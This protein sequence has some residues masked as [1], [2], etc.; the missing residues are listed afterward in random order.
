MS[1]GLVDE[2]PG[3]DAITSQQTLAELSE[4][5]CGRLHDP[6]RVRHRLGG[7]MN[8]LVQAQLAHPRS[9]AD[10]A[11]VGPNTTARWNTS[12]RITTPISPGGSSA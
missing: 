10:T 2:R 8:R 5:V 3:E 11:T 6:Q 9:T 1:E 4:D 7:I 12:L